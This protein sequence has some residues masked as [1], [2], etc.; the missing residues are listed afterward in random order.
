[1]LPQVGSYRKPCNLGCIP[2]LAYPVARGQQWQ[3]LTLQ[4]KHP[5]GWQEP[6]Y[7]QQFLPF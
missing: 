5:A 6:E 1:M 2:F 7:S 3:K 4:H